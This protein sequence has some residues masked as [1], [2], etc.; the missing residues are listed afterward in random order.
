[1]AYELSQELIVLRESLPFLKAAGAAASAKQMNDHG[2][3]HALRVH[4]I[5]AVLSEI[6]ELSDYEKALILAAALLHDIGNVYD[7]DLHH[8]H[9]L[10]LV[11]ILSNRNILPFDKD[12]ARIVGILCK[13]HRKKFIPSFVDR[14][15]N[16]RVGLLASL[17]RVADEL[18]LDYRRSPSFEGATAKMIGVVRQEQEKYHLMVLNILGFRFSIKRRSVRLQIMIK[19]I[20]HASE[21]VARLIHELLA[22]ALPWTIEILPTYKSLPNGITPVKRKAVIFSYFN[23]HGI[24]MALISK[25]QLEALG[26]NVDIICNETETGLPKKFWNEIFCSYDFSKYDFVS[27]IDIMVTQDDINIISNAPK[28]NGNCDFYYAS[29]LTLDSKTLHRISDAGYTVILGNEELL[30]SGTLLVDEMGDWITVA[31]LCNFDDNLISHDISE[32]NYYAAMGV[33]MHVQELWGKDIDLQKRSVEGIINGNL[34]TLANDGRSFET[35]IKNAI[36]PVGD[37]GNVT[38]LKLTNVPG[39]CVYDYSYWHA[40]H[41]GVCIKDR[42]RLRTPYSITVLPGKSSTKIMFMSIDTGCVATPAMRY[43]TE[44]QINQVGSSSTIWHRFENEHEALDSIK[45]AIKNINEYFGDSSEVDITSLQ[46][47]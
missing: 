43:F 44:A 12:E 13:W 40:V 2:H 31:R 30:F 36:V 17:L 42:R 20:D 45:L 28:V 15:T 4:K 37:F 25:K 29:P 26:Y 19:N 38:V 34:G 27:V 21:Q 7:R 33:R 39:R 1:M 18:D 32:E 22:T 11:H 46:I 8:L 3:M 24:V 23:A 6:Y 41:N 35:C 9:S 10:K 5:A 14:N 16:V 47:T